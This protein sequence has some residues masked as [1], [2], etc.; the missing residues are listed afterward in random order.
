[1]PDYMLEHPDQTAGWDVVFDARG[2]LMEPHTGYVIGIGTLEVRAY[3]REAE[4]GIRQE[5]RVPELSLAFPTRGPRNRYSTVLY[6][7]KEGFLPL[8]ERAGFARRFDL[9]I[10]SSKGMGTTAA[11]TLIEHLAPEARI[12]CLHDFDR[13]GFSIL[14]TLLRDTRRYAYRNTPEVIDLG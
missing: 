1:L 13:S 5:I 6:I 14:G 7:E 11:R 9:A 3:L 4:S 10:M 12:L 8:L 2:H